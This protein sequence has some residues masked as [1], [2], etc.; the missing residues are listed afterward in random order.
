MVGLV[1]VIDVVELCGS[2]EMSVI[3]IQ[4]CFLFRIS[5]DIP[6]TSLVPITSPVICTQQPTGDILLYFFHRFVFGMKQNI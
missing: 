3:V 1:G 5:A 2:Q 6:I 4:M